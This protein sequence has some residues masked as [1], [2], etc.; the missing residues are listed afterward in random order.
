MQTLSDF[1]HTFQAK[2]LSALF[3]DK[4]FAA[5]LFDSYEPA[6]FDSEA[7][8]WL[9]KKY[10][11]FF[12]E[13]KETPSLEYFKAE[14]TKV[15]DETFRSE[16]V[17]NLRVAWNNI[18][19]TDLEYTK[20]ATQEFC[21]NQAM[22]E[23][24]FK[25][26]DL[27]KAGKLDEIKGVID[28]ALRKGQGVKPGLNYKE[29]VD[30]RYLETVRDTITT[31]WPI[32]DD[33][34]QGGI[35][36]GNLG[37]V[38]APSGIG[39]T[40]ILCHLGAAAIVAGKTVFHYTFELDDDYTG[41]RYDA[42]TTGITM[43]NLGNHIETIKTKMTKIK[44]DLHIFRYPPRKLSVV[45]LEA[46]IQSMTLSGIKPDLIILDYADLMKVDTTYKRDDLALKALYEDLR[47]LSY[48]VDAGIWSASQTNREGL[49]DNVVEADS[50][51]DGYSKVFTADFLISVSRKM[52]DKANNTAR[53][54]VIKNR[55]GSDGIVFPCN[56]NTSN[57]LIQ[58]RDERTLEGKEAHRVSKEESAYLANRYDDIFAK[59]PES[60]TLEGVL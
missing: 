10:F 20:K 50:I 47:G 39:K 48:E 32:I 14:M 44:G 9:L 38:M 57:G 3:R 17:S 59:K 37:I 15:T 21:Q 5:K 29:E 43:S 7:I 8:R 16:L 23:A 53:L 18:N 34:F 42:I 60:K 25:S 55:Y 51:S 30:R 49:K 11:E 56:F 41:R 40:W 2:I 4:V 54:N 19:A 31:G 12:T 36:T 22:K 58:V 33:L 1:G 52:H 45:G 6:Y 26:V 24:I 35:A 46:H 28:T 13:Y 27:I